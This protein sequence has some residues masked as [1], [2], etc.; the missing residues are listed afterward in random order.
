[1]LTQLKTCNSRWTAIII[2][3]TILE[4]ECSRNWIRAIQKEST[5]LLRVIPCTLANNMLL[6][7]RFSDLQETSPLATVHIMGSKHTSSLVTLTS[8]YHRATVTVTLRQEAPLTQI[9]VICKALNSN[10]SNNV[11]KYLL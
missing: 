7:P 1:M 9:T 10:V 3:S 2:N 4:A 8:A 5:F 11:I 6:S